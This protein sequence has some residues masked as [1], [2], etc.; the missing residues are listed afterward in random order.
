MTT[1]RLRDDDS[2]SIASSQA[3]KRKRPLSP[4]SDHSNSDFRTRK[5]VASEPDKAQRNR[6][7]KRPQ[8]HNGHTAY[9]NDRTSMSSK[10]KVGPSSS[11]ESSDE[12]EAEIVVASSRKPSG[13]PSRPS[14]SFKTLESKS[15][16]NEN[17]RQSKQARIS[18]VVSDDDYAEAKHATGEAST[19]LFRSSLASSSTKASSSISRRADPVNVGS[20]RTSDNTKAKDKSP[21]SHKSSLLDECKCAS[22]S[23]E[24]G[25]LVFECY[26]M[27]VNICE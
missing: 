16:S 10:G 24:N 1:S 5:S 9:P 23:T 11:N 4:G 7:I 26:W 17:K 14:A 12:S 18:Q 22:V 25:G 6:A 27:R 15:S 2:L 20:Q 8:A 13:P 21:K 19:N 3:R